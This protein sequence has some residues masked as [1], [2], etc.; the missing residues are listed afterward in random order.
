MKLGY[1]FSVV[2][3]PCFAKFPKIPPL[4]CEVTALVSFV[5]ARCEEL[6]D[7]TAGDWSLGD[8]ILLK[9][10]S[11]TGL[12]STCR[13]GSAIVLPALPALEGRSALYEGAASSSGTWPTEGADGVVF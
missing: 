7:K 9:G 11:C 1:G 5:G 8:K 12:S 4:A 13:F 2:G 3:P 6:V 10:L